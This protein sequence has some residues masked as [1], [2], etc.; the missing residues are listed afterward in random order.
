MQKYYRNRI[1]ALKNKCRFL[2]LLA[3]VLIAFNIY[4]FNNTSQAKQTETKQQEEVQILN[5]IPLY[6]P[7]SDELTNLIIMNEESL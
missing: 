6:P 5:N 4:T 2:I 7:P 3:L 1:K